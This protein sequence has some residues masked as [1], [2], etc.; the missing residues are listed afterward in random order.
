MTAMSGERV[1]KRNDLFFIVVSLLVLFVSVI[2]IAVDNVFYN[3][4]EAL[5]ISNASKFARDPMTWRS[6]DGRSSGPLNSMVLMWPY[7]LGEQVSLFT[8][9]ITGTFLMAAAWYLTFLSL[10]TSVSIMRIA[11]GGL[12]IIFFAGTRYYDYVHFETEYLSVFLLV[13]ASYIV[14]KIGGDADRFKFLLY[15][16]GIIIGCIPFAK[17]QAAP[18]AVL[19]AAIQIA[20]VALTVVSLR[21]RLYPISSIVAGVLT[22]FALILGP[23]A[24]AGDFKDFWISYIVWAFAYL[25]PLITFS[26][27]LSLLS[28]DRYFLGYLL[29][30]LLISIVGLMCAATRL[31][32]Y[33]PR[34][35]IRIG[36]TMVIAALSVYVGVRGL[37]LAHYLLF[38][39]FPLAWLAGAAWPFDIQERKAR[40]LVGGL[41]A[42]A[43]VTMFATVLFRHPTADVSLNL[44]AN[45]TE[46]A[47]TSGNLLSWV[48]LSNETL[49]IWGWNPAWYVYSNFRPATRDAETLNQLTEGPLQAYY[50]SRLLSDFRASRPSVVIDAAAPGSFHFDDVRLGLKS[51]PDL[52]SKVA[53]DYKLISSPINGEKCPRTYLSSDAFAL[54]KSTFAEIKNITASSFYNSNGQSFPPEL[55]NDFKIY[56]TCVDRWLLP[57]GDI[58]DLT[59]ELRSERMVTAVWLLNTRNGIGDRASLSTRVQLLRQGKVLSEMSTEMRR[60]PYWTVLS[61]S[62]E[63]QLADAVRVFITGFVGIGGGLNEVKIETA[64]H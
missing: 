25:R 3:P 33:R 56:E 10:K 43:I 57:D 51:F 47:F 23:L 61:I 13:A 5:L 21:D 52:E 30:T 12:L 1:E 15:L 24:C 39:I 50:R 42:S 9:R 27:Y 62:N 26:S 48:P 16:E 14:L 22:P 53:A 20:L 63:G 32:R 31:S 34:D 2:P 7:V 49:F 11:V 40:C 18:I 64:K 54:V 17:L 60:Y 28:D 58:G 38:L 59:L 44:T 4:D 36:V 45:G 6:A 55:V 37:G 8:A 35:V 19:I 46:G 41:A 29:S